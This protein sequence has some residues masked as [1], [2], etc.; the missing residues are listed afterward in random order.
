MTFQIYYIIKIILLVY[1]NVTTRIIEIT[2]TAHI[3]FLSDSIALLLLP[4][5][6][7]LFSIA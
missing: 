4:S 6:I 1:S 2:Y 3:I 5:Y 7:C